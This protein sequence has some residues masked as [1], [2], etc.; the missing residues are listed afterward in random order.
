MR[1]LAAAICV[2]LLLSAGLPA[3]ATAASVAQTWPVGI[4]PF[5][6][7]IDPRDGKVYVA[8]SDHNNWSGTEYMWAIDPTVPLP[9]DPA[10]LPRFL[11]PRIQVMSALD[12]DLDRLFVSTAGGLAI[13]DVPT[14]TLVTNVALGT[15]AGVALDKSTHRVYATTLS[16]GASLTGVALV[17]GASG[18][19]LATR[20]ATSPNDAWWDVVQDPVRHRLYVTNGNFGGAPSLVVLD[21]GDLSLV[22]NIPLPAI[23]RLALSVDVARGLVYVGGFSSGSAPFGSLY[24]IDEGSLQIVRTLDVGGG[25]AS[26]FSMTLMPETNT[27]Y[28]SNIAGFNGS[29][30]GNAL[31]TVET[32]TFSV[33]ARLALPFQPGQS[34]IHPDGRLYLAGFDTRQLAV[35]KLTNSAPV[36]DMVAVDPVGARTNDLVNA[37]VT[38]HDPD[39]DAIT[40]TYRWYRNSVLLPDETAATLDLGKP[41]NG[42]R[43][44][45]VTVQVTTSDGHMASA[46]V[47]SSFRVADTA[48][49]VAVSLDDAA[50]R[51]NDTL[52]ATAVG[53][54]ADADVLTYTFT[55]TVNGTVRRTQSGSGTS[56]TFDLS[57]AG[58]GDRADTVSVS[59]VAF[60]GSL[61]SAVAQASATVADS[62]PTVSVSL[63]DTRPSKRTVLTATAAG[64]DADNDTLTY[65]F[66]WR[67]NDKLKQTTSGGAN[68][69]SFDLRAAEAEVGDRVTIDVLVSDGA[70]TASASASATVTPAGR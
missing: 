44:D 21:D 46:S 49:S 40:F 30:P 68:T 4:E 17:D 59:V 27:L 29:Y 3:H 7:T 63:S 16:S 18:S 45:L 64:R 38:A 28:I 67:V 24:A 12:Q 57:L 26:P 48:P 53:S 8:I 37:R 10:A 55:W 61:Q 51:T 9:W 20:Q 23:P 50:P 43:G 39:G 34:A 56:D 60:D 70:A 14:H 13:V 65:T 19:V 58:N 15:T 31:V 2:A 47:S 54:D 1:R 41:G 62:A 35:I 52:I 69:S 42:D 22:A 66:T 6:V 33:V 5:G 11:L 25:I 32:S 36:I